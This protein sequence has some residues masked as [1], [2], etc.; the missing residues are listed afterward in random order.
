MTARSEQ[1]ALSLAWAWREMD[2]PARA[3]QEPLGL[4]VEELCGLLAWPAGRQQRPRQAGIA[5]QELSPFVHELTSNN[6]C[7]LV[8]GVVTGTGGDLFRVSMPLLVC[9]PESLEVPR[10]R[11]QR[12]GVTLQA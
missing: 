12:G 9:P 4:C 3:R 10:L 6:E 1:P 5:E 2:E 7:Q 11:G 8:T